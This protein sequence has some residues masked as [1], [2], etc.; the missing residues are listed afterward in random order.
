MDLPLGWHTHLVVSR[1]GGSEVEERT[2]HL[3]VRTPANPGYHWGNFV[4]VTDP[5]AVADAAR[6]VS[7]F[8]E[9]FPDAGHRSIGLVADPVDDGAWE[10]AG[11]PVSRDD[12]L[13]ARRP[14]QRR[15]L[16][17]GY[18]ARELGTD[19]D[20]TQSTALRNA[21]FPGQGGF[22][23][24]RTA[25]RAAMAA[26]GETAWFGAF[27]D[28]VLVSELGIADCGAG[29]WRYQ[30]VVTRADHRRRG[31]TSHLLGVADAFARDR[32]AAA[33]VIVADANS[34]ASRLYRS[35]GLDEAAVHAQAYRFVVS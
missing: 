24:A 28:G 6:W 16:A 5:T 7:L 23:L 11:L 14:V 35:L 8:E 2:D 10:A 29:I 31:L 1:L 21:A 12:L 18:L 32:G 20:W 33:T 3:V 13:V 19:A 4:L 34:D 17:A 30:P 9:T 26:R 22:E 27:A 25:T 15:A